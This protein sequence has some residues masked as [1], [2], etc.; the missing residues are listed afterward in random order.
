MASPPTNK[1][2][3]HIT[4]DAKVE[5]G[6]NDAQSVEDSVDASLWENICTLRKKTTSGFVFLTKSIG[7]ITATIGWIALAIILPLLPLAGLII[8]AIHKDDCPADKRIPI[9]LIVWSS[10]LLM[11]Q[12]IILGCK[13]CESARESTCSKAVFWI[14]DVFIIS[15]FIYGSVL[16]FGIYKP[17]Y[18]GDANTPNLCNPLDIARWLEESKSA[19]LRQAAES[20]ERELCKLQSRSDLQEKVQMHE[21]QVAVI[22]L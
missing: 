20:L 7:L 12:I 2:S 11:R 19:R 1:V 4:D 3:Q 8:G 6:A 15:S 21:D 5:S 10:V 13:Q 14:V 22:Q 18:E 17:E 16:I 9:W